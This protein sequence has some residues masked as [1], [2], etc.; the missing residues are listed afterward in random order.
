MCLE[1][2]HFIRRSPTDIHVS[3]KLYIPDYYT[4]DLVCL[5]CK[6]HYAVHAQYYEIPIMP[7]TYIYNNQY[8]VSHSHMASVQLIC[9]TFNSECR[10]K[11]QQRNLLTPHVLRGGTGDYCCACKSKSERI[12]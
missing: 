6:F 3:S 12:T 9:H 11:K 1:I 4:Y 2:N 5:V 10:L 8:A 7:F